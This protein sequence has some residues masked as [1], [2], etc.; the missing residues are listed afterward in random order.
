MLLPHRWASVGL[1]VLTLVISKD[2]EYVDGAY[3]NPY[4]GRLPMFDMPWPAVRIQRQNL[5][6]ILRALHICKRRP[7][8]RNWLQ[9]LRQKSRNEMVQAMLRDLMTCLDAEPFFWWWVAKVDALSSSPTS[10]SWVASVLV[11]LH[12]ILR[13]LKTSKKHIIIIIDVLFPLRSLFCDT[14]CRSEGAWHGFYLK[15]TWCLR[16][17]FLLPIWRWNTVEHAYIGI[18][19][20]Y[21]HN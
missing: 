3:R 20:T 19:Q 8:S 17:C 2:L 15:P 21:N 7:E 13:S 10:I 4:P 6:T 5:A 18:H 1:E 11:Q 12:D 16:K 9:D 14:F